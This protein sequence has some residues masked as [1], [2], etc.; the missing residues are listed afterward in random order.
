MNILRSSAWPCK[1]AVIRIY[2]YGIFCH[3]SILQFAQA[4]GGLRSLGSLWSFGTSGAVLSRLGTIWGHLE[5]SWGHLG[6]ILSRLETIWGHLEPSWG[7]LGAMLSRLAAKTASRE[8]HV[9]K[10]MFS[11]MNFNDFMIPSWAVLGRLGA[12]LGPSWAVLGPSWA[13]LGLL[14]AILGRSWAI[15][16][17]LLGCSWGVWGCLGLSWAVLGPTR[18]YLV[19]S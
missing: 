15:L 1:F 13:V 5:P 8:P 11:A 6:T 9:A 10:T 17:L 3:A 18:G 2:I 12:I 14:G 4:F 16:G 19:L 7:H